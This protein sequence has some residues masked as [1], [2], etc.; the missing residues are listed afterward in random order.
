MTRAVHEPSSALVARL[1]EEGALV[2][3]DRL[4]EAFR[5]G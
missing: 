2:P 3:D 1:V 4:T 5:R